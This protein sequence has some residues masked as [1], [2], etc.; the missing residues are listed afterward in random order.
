MKE[1]AATGASGI[2]GQV[3]E[4]GRA[5]ERYMP[6]PHESPGSPIFSHGGGRVLKK[7][8]DERRDK[9]RKRSTQIARGRADWIGAKQKPSQRDLRKQ[10]RLARYAGM[11]KLP[12]EA[13]LARALQAEKR[14]REAARE[15]S[16]RE[17]RAAERAARARAADADMGEG[18]YESDGAPSSAKRRGRISGGSLEG[19]LPAG[20]FPF[21]FTQPQ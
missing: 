21:K 18:G 13:G 19:A 7:A 15:T 5:V 1:R 9:F 3:E 20:P 14:V 17:R 16:P 4:L 2:R 11:R 6:S 10:V 8:V 12:A